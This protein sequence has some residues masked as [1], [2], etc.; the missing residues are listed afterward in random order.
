[1]SHLQTLTIRHDERTRTE[2]DL[3]VPD[4]VTGAVV[5]AHGTGSGRHSPRN[6]MVAAALND[7]GMATLLLDL[8]TPLE[9]A[10]E[11]RGATFRFDTEHLASRLING[12]AAVRR[13]ES[14]ATLP[15]GYF[16]ASTGSAAALIA[17]ATHPEGVAAVVSRGG[18][19][20]LAGAHLRDV[21]APTLLI[22]GGRDTP[23]I[24]MNRRAQTQLG[25]P[26][27]FIVIP[28]ATH[29]FDEDGAL[30]KVS[31]LAGDWFATHLKR[32]G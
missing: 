25:G 27:E 1:M 12:V 15:I 22:V 18:R 14:L 32:N 24:D 7:R 8:L 10:A 5:F 16:G 13:D 30:E 17:S 29:L 23:V 20:D 6:R 28:G 4:E 3:M 19:P 11:R 2:A 31:E 26:S 21:R 9:D